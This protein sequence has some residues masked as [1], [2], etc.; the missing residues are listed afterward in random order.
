M[1]LNPF[2]TYWSMQFNWTALYLANVNQGPFNIPNCLKKQ[3]R[4]MELHLLLTD[5]FETSSF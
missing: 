3:M 5:V 1:I 2:V 4:A